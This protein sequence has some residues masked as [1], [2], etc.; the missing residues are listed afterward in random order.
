[1]SPSCSWAIVG[2]PD[3]DDIAV[4]LDPL[5]GAG[6]LPVLWCAHL[7]FLL[8]GADRMLGAWAPMF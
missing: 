4:D 5:M 2:D 3:R 7:V 1:M 6:V 8:P